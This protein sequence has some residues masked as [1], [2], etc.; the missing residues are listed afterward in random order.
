MKIKIKNSQT[1]LQNLKTFI[2]LNSIQECFIKN[3][4]GFKCNVPFFVTCK[5]ISEVKIL[6]YR[7]E[8]NVNRYHRKEK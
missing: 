8:A 1:L 7:V 3:H 5:I 6:S 4:I 2:R